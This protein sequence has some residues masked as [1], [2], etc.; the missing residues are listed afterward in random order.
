M[1]A[2]TIAAAALA[3]CSAV[4]STAALFVFV[5]LL[6]LE[7]PP[8]PPHATRVV[9]AA[10]YSVTFFRVAIKIPFFFSLR[11]GQYGRED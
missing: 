3:I 11:K 5:L 4:V 8:P 6:G 9:K 1:F 10:T 7:S 2:V